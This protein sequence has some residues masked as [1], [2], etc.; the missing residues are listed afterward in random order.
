MFIHILQKA[1]DAYF[2]GEIYTL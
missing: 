2:V 1:D